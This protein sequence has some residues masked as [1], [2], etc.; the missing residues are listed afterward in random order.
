MAD[1]MQTSLICDA[2]DMAAGNIEL[3]EGCVFHSDRG[4]Q[5]TSTQ[6]HVHLDGH[7][8]TGSMGRTGVCWEVSQRRGFHPPLLSEPGVTVSRHRAPTVEPVGIAPC[9]Q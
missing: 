7:G 2:I 8:I 5:Y 4:S 6:F 1:H 9:F 3:A